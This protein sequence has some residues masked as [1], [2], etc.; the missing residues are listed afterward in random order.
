MLCFVVPAFLGKVARSHDGF[1]I[2]MVQ[3]DNPELG[4]YR[5]HLRLS[6]NGTE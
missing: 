1:G 3:A 4:I 2:H 5:N 6:L